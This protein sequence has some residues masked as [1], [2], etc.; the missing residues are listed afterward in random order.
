MGD[1]IK[2]RYFT[3]KFYTKSILIIVLFLVAIQAVH[4]TAYHEHA[5]ALP[6]LESLEESRPNRPD[7][8]TKEDKKMP[9]DPTIFEHKVDQNKANHNKFGT[10]V[11]PVHCD[12]RCSGHGQCQAVFKNSRPTD[13]EFKNTD[14]LYICVCDEFYI[15][16]VCGDCMTGYFGPKCKPCRRNPADNEICGKFGVCDDGIHGRGD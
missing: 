9:I 7:A 16:N 8:T 5:Y 11:D 12:K 13:D 3:A 2:P 1:F 15:G 14:I 6:S 10:V 4:E